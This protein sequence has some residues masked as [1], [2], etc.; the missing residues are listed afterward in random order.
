MS[1][2]WLTEVIAREKAYDEGY[3][4]GKNSAAEQIFA[5]FS[6]ALEE[7]ASFCHRLSERTFDGQTA[8]SANG[9]AEAYEDIQSY[10][11]QLKNKYGVK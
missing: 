9:A 4:A 5:D 1:S 2:N 8:C 11:D 7:K 10:L 6:K 3:E